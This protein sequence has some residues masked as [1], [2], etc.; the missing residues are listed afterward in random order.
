MSARRRL[1][2]SVLLPV[3]GILL[4]GC[5]PEGVMPAEPTPVILNVIYPT[6]TPTARQYFQT[7]EALFSQGQ[8]ELAATFYTFAIQGDPYYIRAYSR[9]AQ[10]YQNLDDVDSAIAYYSIAIQL[11]PYLADNYFQRGLVY[12]T[13]GLTAQATAD[14]ERFLELAAEDTVMREI[15]ENHLRELRQGEP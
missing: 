15:A 9:L 3:L 11:A 8:Y 1:R 5:L 6:P 10:T 13:I 12:K 2:F 7:A 4:A 14:F